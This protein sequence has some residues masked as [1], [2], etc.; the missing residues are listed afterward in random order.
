MRE[1]ISVYLTEESVRELKEIREIKAWTDSQKKKNENK[2]KL[3]RSV[4]M[5]GHVELKKRGFGNTCPSEEFVNQLLEECG[6]KL[7]FDYVAR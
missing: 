6:R 1:K 7:G 4:D 5:G 2:G 3:L